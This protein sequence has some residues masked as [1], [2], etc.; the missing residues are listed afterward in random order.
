[1]YEKMIPKVEQIEMGVHAMPS[2]HPHPNAQM[3]THAPM[4]PHHVQTM[5]G[6]HHSI[7]HHHSPGPQMTALTTDE[8]SP[9]SITNNQVNIFIFTKTKKDIFWFP[10]WSIAYIL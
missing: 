9:L 4:A 8:H 7:N 5:N 3:V 2:L 10:L 1:M 6:I